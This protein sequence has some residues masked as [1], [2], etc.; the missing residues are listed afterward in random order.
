MLTV[1]ISLSLTISTAVGQTNYSFTPSQIKD[2]A[3]KLETRK[4]LLSDTVLYR[5]KIRGLEL[6]KEKKDSVIKY[7]EGKYD[8]SEMYIS[9]LEEDL[10]LVVSN[11]TKLRKEN[12]S[13]N[14]KL[15][16]SNTAIPISFVVGAALA[17]I[18]S[19]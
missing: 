9:A 12:K 4:I 5:S 13:L 18:L 2:I 15:T 8:V 10:S 7:M 1:L 17:L 19:K 11:N 6:Q 16:I 14:R 3:F